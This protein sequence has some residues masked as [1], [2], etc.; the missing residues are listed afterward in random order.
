MGKHY[1][2]YHS[3]SEKS[4]ICWCF[5]KNRWANLVTIAEVNMHWFVVCIA[6]CSYRLLCVHVPRLLPV[7]Q[8]C[9]QKNEG[10]SSRA[11]H[12]SQMF[13]LV[14][15]EVCTDSLRLMPVSQLS[16][17]YNPNMIPSTPLP[18]ILFPRLILSPELFFWDFDKNLLTRTWQPTRYLASGCLAFADNAISMC[19]NRVHTC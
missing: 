3:F 14:G 19:W 17:L 1:E 8:W 6:D 16:S 7:F 9:T 18:R 11:Y 13:H 10:A 4:I 15:N 5:W 2:P 12:F